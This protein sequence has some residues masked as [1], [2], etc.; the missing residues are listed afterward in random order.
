MF[1]SSSSSLSAEWDE[2]G[3]RQSVSTRT[4]QLTEQADFISVTALAWVVLQDVELLKHKCKYCQASPWPINVDTLLFMPRLRSL[5]EDII[6]ALH[7]SSTH[8]VYEK[9]LSA[10]G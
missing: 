4:G 1:T 8:D 6:T 2:A 10:L 5:V 9:A 7:A 3:H